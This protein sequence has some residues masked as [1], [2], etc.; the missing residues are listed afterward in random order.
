MMRQKY[1]EIIDHPDWL[2]KF[3]SELPSSEAHSFTVTLQRN[4]NFTTTT[5]KCPFYVGWKNLPAKDKDKS[6]FD[7]V[8]IPRIP[9][10]SRFHFAV[11][12]MADKF[13]VFDVGSMEGFSTEKRTHS[14]K[15]TCEKSVPGN[16]KVL[17]F[18]ENEIFVIQVGYKTTIAF[19]P[20]E[21]TSCVICFDKARSVRFASCSHCAVCHEC[22]SKI[23]ECPLCRHP[24]A[25]P[26]HLTAHP[27]Q[28]F[29][30]SSPA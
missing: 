13:H 7:Q 28:T 4:K 30:N 11:I 20:V 16:R 22:L 8:N 25:E 2:Q 29:A 5:V 26:A 14:S 1:L 17:K 3:A 18:D 27:N 9:G 24:I 15:Y 21:T 6:G 19:N 10:S 23:D 12:K